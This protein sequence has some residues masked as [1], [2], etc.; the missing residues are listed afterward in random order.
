MFHGA[1][2]F[3]RR[4]VGWATA[5]PMT[6]QRYKY[7]LGF[8]RSGDHI[9]FLNRQKAPW[10]GRWNGVGGKLDTNESPYEC[11]VRETFE[12][13]GLHLP[14][15]KDRGVMRWFRN[16]EDLG[17]VH[18][19]TA[20]ISE[21]EKDAYKTPKS[22]CHEGILDWKLLDWLLHPE[23]TGVVD[24]VK[25]MLQ[26]LFEAGPESVWISTYDNSVLESC[27]YTANYVE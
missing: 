11:I 15:Y 22:F 10:M 21:A 14:Q 13:T 17:G 26:H 20:E 9:L 16:G 6:S 8:I 2:L 7:T 4:V 24:N 1:L 23:N 25:I 12:E 27:T 18:I 5:H 19:F 3:N